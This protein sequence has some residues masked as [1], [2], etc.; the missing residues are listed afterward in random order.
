MLF[1]LKTIN[2][3]T[4]F[5]AGVSDNKQERIQRV[6]DQTLENKPKDTVTDSESPTPKSGPDEVQTRNEVETIISGTIDHSEPEPKPKPEPEPEPGTATVKTPYA[7]LAEKRQISRL[8]TISTFEDENIEKFEIIDEKDND[9][10]DTIND[11][12]N[13]TTTTHTLKVNVSKHRSSSLDMPSGLLSNVFASTPNSYNSLNHFAS[14]GL[15]DFAGQKEFYA[16]HQAFL[17]SRAI[18]VLV[19]EFMEDI[20]TDVEKKYFEDMQHSGGRYIII[21]LVRKDFEIYLLSY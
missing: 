1:F 3:S 20:R 9:M 8:E 2:T 4:S 7:E 21:N 18:Y 6:I 10:K 14:C 13:N 15:W 12:T 17:T 16:T 5:S 19:A 11:S